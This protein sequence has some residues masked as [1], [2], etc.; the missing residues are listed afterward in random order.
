VPMSVVSACVSYRWR[1]APACAGVVSARDLR[2]GPRRATDDRRD[3]MV[4][5]GCGVTR[6]ARR[7]VL[8]DRETRTALLRSR[9]PWKEIAGGE[10]LLRS[11]NTSARILVLGDFI[12]VV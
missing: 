7:R 3:S 1:A 9:R 6:S 10:R 2:A 12:T 5:G 11:A 4:G 8:G